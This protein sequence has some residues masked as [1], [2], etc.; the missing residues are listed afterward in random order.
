MA[1][2]V[3]SFKYTLELTL[4]IDNSSYV[5]E[6]NSVNSIIIDNNYDKNNMPIIYLSIRLNSTMYN[7]MVRN[8]NIG[9]LNMRLFKFNDTGVSVRNEPYI[10]DRFIYMMSTDPNYDES[11]ERLTS[12]S[13][14]GNTENSGS[15]LEGY[16]GLISVKSVNDNKELFNDIIKNTDSLSVVYK[17]TKHMTMCIEPF[18]NNPNIDQFIIP[19]ITSITNLLK[20]LNNYFCFYNSGYRYFRDFDITYLL[21]MKGVPV[22]TKNSIYNS[23]IISIQDPLEASGKVNSMEIDNVNHAYIIYVD[24]NSTSIN[25]DK[26]TNKSFNT[27]IG[28]DT[29]GNTLK[30][31]LDLPDTPDF[32]EKVILERVNKNNLNKILNTKAIIESLSVTLTITKAEIDSTILTP[33]KEYQVKNYSGSKEYD[34]RY[35]LSF[36]KEIMY[37]QN[38][39]YIGN[40]IFGLRRVTED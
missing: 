21:S 37:K 15:Y 29:L 20:Y 16:I 6:S 30:E 10:E 18:D 8:T 14:T 31:E 25:I 38:D 40:V 12:D 22:K 26:V 34:G 23:V 13:A 27:I 39:K 3:A 7:R 35:V 11:S 9:I 5:I 1:S 2:L 19:P 33:N 28:V 4:L 36:K 32:T 17:Y 24:A